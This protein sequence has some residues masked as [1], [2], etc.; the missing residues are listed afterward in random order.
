MS[1]G[2]LLEK[3]ASSFRRKSKETPPPQIDPAVQKQRMIDDAKVILEKVSEKGLDGTKNPFV[4]EIEHKQT[5]GGIPVET[6]E[7]KMRPGEM[8]RSGFIDNDQ[9][10]VDVLKSDQDLVN[11]LGLTH[12]QIVEPLQIAH[13][14]HV[15]SSCEDPRWEYE[16]RTPDGNTERQKRVV[17]IVYHGKTYKLSGKTYRGVQMTP[18][19]L[20]TRKTDWRDST[21]TASDLTITDPET[22]HELNF[23]GLLVHLIRDYGFYEGNTRYRV[24]PEEIAS[25]F[26]LKK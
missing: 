8:S 15:I 25:F 22:G 10:L 20:D 24:G 16:V 11:K 3:I 21:N 17:D 9:K 5:I 18:F 2:S 19:L 6:I 26:G 4:E 12:K 23:S 7:Q 13:N 1:E 14:Q